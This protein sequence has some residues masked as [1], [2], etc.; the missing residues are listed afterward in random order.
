MSV[1]RSSKGISDIRSRHSVPETV[2]RLEA[3]LRE[4]GIALF[5]CIDHSGEAAKVGLALRPTRLLIF[6]RPEA[7]TP[8]MAERPRV[9]ID[10]PLKLL[11]W[12]DEHGRV[13]VSHNSAAYLLDRHA[14]PQD[15]RAVLAV[16]EPLARAAAE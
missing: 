1:A 6:G 10:L 14:L 2:A 16:V 12:E 8:L 15:Q 3:L 11:V 13:W 4:Q 5:A 7:G 9:A